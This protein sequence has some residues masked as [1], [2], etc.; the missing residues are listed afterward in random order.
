VEEPV[1]V[2]NGC[3]TG[4][5]ALLISMQMNN[6]AKL[7][8]HFSYGP[9]V[10]ET[11][12]DE[13][14]SMPVV[15]SPPEGHHIVKVPSFTNEGDRMWVKSPEDGEGMGYWVK[16]HHALP[17][18]VSMEDFTNLHIPVSLNLRI[19]PGQWG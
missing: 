10:H 2:L 13:D 6:P 3:L 8:K 15:P 9:I 18:G 5:I 17:E 1:Q 14:S 12:K 7:L 19:E 16:L 4:T 11:K